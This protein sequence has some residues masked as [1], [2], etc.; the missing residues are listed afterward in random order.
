MTG[1]PT[2]C[3]IW[4]KEFRSVLKALTA[5]AGRMIP[6]Q[7]NISGR[8]YK[9][10]NFLRLFRL[11]AFMTDKYGP[12]GTGM[13]TADFFPHGFSKI[14]AWKNLRSFGRKWERIGKSLSL[15]T[16]QIFTVFSKKYT[17]LISWMNGKISP[18]P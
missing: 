17:A 13:N 18:G 9:K 7:N 15:Y 14:T 4:W 16:V 10:T 12:T 2:N 3:I 1:T 5:A 11:P 8:L 6:A